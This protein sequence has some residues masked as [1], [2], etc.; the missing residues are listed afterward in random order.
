MDQREKK[1]KWMDESDLRIKNGKRTRS[2]IAAA[3]RHKWEISATIKKNL[4]FCLRCVGMIYIR[5]KGAI[6][7]VLQRS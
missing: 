2:I 4:L 3:S 1:G 5:K 6:I 7:A